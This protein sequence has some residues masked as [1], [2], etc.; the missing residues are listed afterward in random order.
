MA[1]I[2]IVNPTYHIQCLEDDPLPQGVDKGD[3]GDLHISPRNNI[4]N[5]DM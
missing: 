1:S 5:V 4:A 3:K 2:E